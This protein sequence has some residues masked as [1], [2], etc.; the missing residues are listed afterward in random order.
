MK[1]RVAKVAEIVNVAYIQAMKD[2][3]GNPM[4]HV[5]KSSRQSVPAK[6]ASPRAA[7][8]ASA[9]GLGVAFVVKK[10]TFGLPAGSTII[11]PS[12]AE[13]RRLQKLGL[14][15]VV[16]GQPG[17]RTVFRGKTRKP[18]DPASKG[19]ATLPAVAIDGIPVTVVMDEAA[20][21]PGPRAKAALRGLEIAHE[22]L[23]SSGGSYSLD[24][25]RGLMHGVS[26]QR[27]DKRV[28]EGSLLAVPGPS[29]KRYYPAVQFT[30][31]G[32]VVHGLRAVHKA[33]PTAN[34]W[35]V[36][37]FLIHPDPRLNGRRPIDLLKAGNLDLVVEAAQRM[38]DHGA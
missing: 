35:T 23:R 13:G 30:A 5:H 16:L 26:R 33:L 3:S 10:K 21:V 1:S 2:G 24:Q 9:A 32:T 17:R 12:A 37:N 6:K 31:G 38:G 7:M 8:K 22:D 36:L 25:V 29:N 14:T 18:V 4:A 15:P 34:S 19:V 11:P 20:F 28:R 27:I